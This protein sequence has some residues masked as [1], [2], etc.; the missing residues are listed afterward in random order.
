MKKF[1][2]ISMLVAIGGI[3]AGIVRRQDPASTSVAAIE[4]V[5]TTTTTAA[6]P[7]VATTPAPAGAGKAVV[8]ASTTPTTARPATTTTIAPKAT[9]V[10]TAPVAASTTTTTS[11]TATTAVIVPNCSA[12]VANPTVN[13]GDAQEVRVTSNQ[14]TTKTRITI[15]YPKFGTGSPNPRQTFTPTTDSAGSVTQ[16]FNVIDTSTVTVPVTVEFYTPDG[17]ISASRC[18]TTFTSTS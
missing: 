10:T 13:K 9:A 5:E 15:Q 17:R 4:T 18:Q 6:A 12:S 2:I 16:A 7:V 14:P 11:T 3:G 8:K 1:V